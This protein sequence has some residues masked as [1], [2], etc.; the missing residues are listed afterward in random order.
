MG[1]CMLITMPMAIP[2]RMIRHKAYSV[3]DRGIPGHGTG[4]PTVQIDLRAFADDR[5]ASKHEHLTCALVYQC[6]TGHGW[7][8]HG[9]DCFLEFSSS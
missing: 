7:L 8:D 5:K 1:T 2:S 3:A 6:R 4:L 9:R